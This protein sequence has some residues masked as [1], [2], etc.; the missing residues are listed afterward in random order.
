MELYL[1][2]LI[3]GEIVTLLGLVCFVVIRVLNRFG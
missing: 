2:L 3:E 1:H